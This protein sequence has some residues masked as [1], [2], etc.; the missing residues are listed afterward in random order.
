MSDGDSRDDP[1]SV[2]E[3]LAE[4]PRVSDPVARDLVRSRVAAELFDH[5]PDPVRIGRFHLL[6]RIGRGGMGRVYAAYDP[7]LDRRVAIKLVRAGDS[8]SRERLLGEAQALARLSHPHVVPVH[9]VEVIGDQVCIVM[10]FVRGQTVRAWRAAAPR[11]WREVL[12]I[13][14]QIGE[15]L[16]AAHRAGLVHRDVKPDNAIV[17]ADGRVRVVDFGLARPLEIA[18]GAVD[19]AVPHAAVTSPAGTPRYMAPEQAAGRAVTAAADQYAFCVALREALGDAAP[20]LGPVLERGTAD[21]PAARFASMSELLRALAR[22]PAAARRRR[23]IAGGAAVLL[24]GAGALAGVVWA[25]RTTAVEPCAGG[26]G[27]LAAV[28]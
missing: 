16:E 4:T 14:R 1:A 11:T 28:W 3:A 10:E 12:A 18:D 22:D 9:D 25:G 8:G 23:M 2:I 19:P 24:A 15:G 5:A 20:W 6:E 13:H 17:G 26:A 27:E 7:D 21:D